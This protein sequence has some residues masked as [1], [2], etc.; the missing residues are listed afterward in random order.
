MTCAYESFF[1]QKTYKKATQKHRFLGIF[2]ETQNQTNFSCNNFSIFGE[3]PLNKLDYICADI[4]SL[5]GGFVWSISKGL[6]GD[7]GDINPTIFDKHKNFTTPRFSPF[8]HNFKQNRH[9]KRLRFI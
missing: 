3:L 6:L 2:Y 5:T 9:K 1:R 4:T 8:L 7:L